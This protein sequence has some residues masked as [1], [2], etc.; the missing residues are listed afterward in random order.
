MQL[1]TIRRAGAYL[2]LLPSLA[3]RQFTQAA[4]QGAIHSCRAGQHGCKSWCEGIVLHSGLV[5]FE[6]RDN[7][8]CKAYES[9][10]KNIKM[11]Q[12]SLSPRLIRPSDCA[13]MVDG[14]LDTFESLNSLDS[15]NTYDYVQVLAFFTAYTESA[16]IPQV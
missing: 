5:Q 8:Q 13:R 10:I 9:S 16:S 14:Q 11:G 2:K 1:L 12:C 15:M 7:P 4:T 3:M 6:R